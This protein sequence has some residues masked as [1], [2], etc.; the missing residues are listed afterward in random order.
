MDLNITSAKALANGLKS[1]SEALQLVDE[2]KQFSG[3]LTEALKS[4]RLYDKGFSYDV[5]A[6]VKDSRQRLTAAACS[7]RNRRASQRC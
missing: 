6:Y 1:E 2:D 3:H 4:W 5:V 7:D